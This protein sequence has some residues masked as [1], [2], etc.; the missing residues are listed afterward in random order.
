MKDEQTI[1]LPEHIIEQVNKVAHES[2]Q[3]TGVLGC[4]PTDDAQLQKLQEEIMGIP[5]T[6]P[7]R[8]QE[9]HKTRYG[10]DD[11]YSLTLEIEG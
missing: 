4:E 11:G 9:V 3:L 8:E 1:R 10:P 6:L 7:P 5:K 2:G